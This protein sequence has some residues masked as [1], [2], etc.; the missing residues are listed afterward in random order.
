MNQFIRSWRE[1]L[2]YL[3]DAAA[4]YG[5]VFYSEGES[6]A[7]F[8]RPVIDA[9]ADV[10]DGTVYYLAS[11]ADDRVLL[12]APSH[13][14]SFYIGKG[15]AR[16]YVLNNMRADVAAM[17]MPDLN[18][19]HIKRSPKTRHYAYLHHSLVSTHMIYRKGAFDHF[20]SMLCV[21]PH[22][23]EETREW[24]ASQGLPAKQLFEHGHPPLDTL[25]EAAR[26]KSAPPIGA[27]KRLNI[28]L[29]P[30][31][32]PQGLMETR[33]EEVIRILLDAGHIVRVRPHPMTR[34]SSGS[35]LDSLAVTF[36]DHPSFDMNEDTTKYEA[37][38][39]SHVMISDWSG[40]AM[41]FA[42]GLGRPVLFVDVP[43]KINNPDYTALT[44]TPLEVSY[45]EEV[46]RI[47]R[48]DRL[49]ELPAALAS[50]QEGAP[51]FQARMPA[52]R[53]RHFYHIGTSAKQGAKVLAELAASMKTQAN[54]SFR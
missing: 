9:L 2:K 41:E 52:L 38:F 23:K 44:A 13:I 14:R 47:I 16:T 34:E 49:D 50:L 39:Q 37:L 42:F 33:A 43:R 36:A 6:Y 28:L 53:K 29:A 32:G 20:D 11:D 7:P 51:S 10:Y 12:D 15:S 27:D 25:I 3:G 31:W 30:S 46:G 19:F 18:T 22:H 48:P 8:L 54:T 40:V 5:I 26:N 24:E 35:A 4:S 21:G 45:R 17:T 1:S